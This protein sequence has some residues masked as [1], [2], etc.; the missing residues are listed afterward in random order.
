MERICPHCGASSDR[1][2]FAG[3]HCLDCWLE[4]RSDK[5]PK[6]VEIRVC[7]R[8]E[9][10]WRE[11]EWKHAGP[12][13]IAAI[14]EAVMSKAKAPGHYN[15]EASLWEGEVEEGGGK[16]VFSLPL[17]IKWDKTVCPDCSRSTSGY[18]E[19][20][21]QLRG[22][23]GWV[24]SR[25]K[26]LI[27]RLERRTWLPRIEDMHGGIDIYVGMKKSVPQMLDYEGMKFQRSEK[28]SG[29]KQGKRLYRSTFLVREPVEGGKAGDEEKDRKRRDD[30]AGDEE[31]EGAEAGEEKEEGGSEA[32]EEGSGEAG[33]ED[34]AGADEDPDAEAEERGEEE[35]GKP[36]GK[37]R[38]L[39]ARLDDTPLRRPN[40]R[41]KAK[42]KGGRVRKR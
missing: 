6:E 20:I 7:Q 36:G 26:R 2:A 29:E 3:E 21:I 32:D 39:P 15:V 31:G 16:A 8:C 38:R 41:S 33:A 12:Q 42:G 10:I 14:V 37:K 28:L 25:A 40:P 24:E 23:R 34:E 1:K 4:A 27:R 19:G 5:W 35:G 13:R 11:K 18:F 22:S 30:E 9:R 17:E